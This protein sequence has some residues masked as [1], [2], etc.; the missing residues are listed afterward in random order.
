[1]ESS[2]LV[3]HN[4]SCA[5]VFVVGAARS[6]TTLLYDMLLSTGGFA[7][8]LGESNIF[9]LLAPR[10]GD[11]AIRQNR[12]RMLRAWLGSA[13]F[14]ISGLT[15][16]DVE[17]KILSDCGN[18]GDFLRIVMDEVAQQQ[19]VRRWAG[20]TP[21]DILHLH[22]IKETIPNALVIHI[23][24]D[25]RDVSV[26]LAR[27]RYIQ[28]LPWK[29]RVTPEGAALYWEW[30]VQ[31]G[32]AASLQLGNDYTEVRFEE[33]VRNPGSVLQKLSAFL[34]HNLDYDRIMKTRIGVV[35]KPNSSFQNSSGS[36]FNPI[37]RWKKELS[38]DQLRRIEALVGKTLAGLGYELGTSGRDDHNPV[39]QAWNRLLYRQ[40]FA[41]KLRSKQ[42]SLLRRFRKPLTSKDIDEIVLVDE[43]AASHLR[44]AALAEKMIS[45]ERSAQQR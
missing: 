13:L 17:S 28:P 37:G 43:N 30:I 40:F 9:N 11:L 29:E 15:R 14:R 21:E 5:P 7:L 1:M 12:E 8:Y 26:S 34:D 41:L 18:A 38:T 2:P 3:L 23:I 39:Y 36:E 19:G 27:K 6:G 10:F 31:K 33:L 16:S 24:R 45:V 35:A 42:N 32:R 20:D 4:R 22:H 44:A 25:G